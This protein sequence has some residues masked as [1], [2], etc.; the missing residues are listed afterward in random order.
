MTELSYSKRRW[1]VDKITCTC[2]KCGQETAVGFTE[3]INLNRVMLSFM[4]LEKDKQDLILLMID[5]ALYR[6]EQHHKK[7]KK[8]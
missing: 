8:P 5:G 1:G 4:E 2:D 7:R 6:A 3:W